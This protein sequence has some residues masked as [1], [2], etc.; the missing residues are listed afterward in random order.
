LVLALLKKY[1]YEEAALIL[2]G[3]GV[4]EDSPVMKLLRFAACKKNLDA[5]ANSPQFKEAKDTAGYPEMDRECLEI[6]EY[7]NVVKLLQRIGHL[8]D[9]LLRLNPLVTELQTSFL[10]QRLG[11]SVDSITEEQRSSG[12]RY[13]A[14]INNE[15]LVKRDKIREFDPKLLAYI[16]EC[17]KGEY[18]DEGY[19]NIKLQNCLIS[20]FLQKNSD[21]QAR[22]FSNFL[23]HMET[24][25]RD[26]NLAAHSLCG[27]GEDKIARKA[28][29]NSEQI[30]S[31]LEN[32]IIYIFR[33]QCKREIFTVFDTINAQIS[34]ALERTL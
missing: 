19:I 15:R 12:K 1:N 17:Y 10:K 18:R 16:D 2:K 26:R 3:Y 24:L 31:K 34:L 7:F 20:Y 28:R 32:L 27:I 22:S 6:C 29:M 4:E 14:A 8:T 33:G 25:N 13:G 5:A 11:F 30:V 23:Q 21:E 9:F